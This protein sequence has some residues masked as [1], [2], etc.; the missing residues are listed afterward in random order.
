M[1]RSQALVVALLALPLGC[2]ASERQSGAS[3]VVSAS[4]AA[5]SKLAP[6]ASGA[7]PATSVVPPASGKAEQ[8]RPTTL[9][10]VRMSAAVEPLERNDKF[11]APLDALLR[12][13]RLGEV[14]NGGSVLKANGTVEYVGFEV[15]VY[16]AR[17]AVPVVIETLREL[18]APKGTSVEELRDDEPAIAHPVW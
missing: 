3:A 13:Q 11:E 18:K 12:E 4:A 6:T 2:R 5:A 7:P 9:L 16:D 15:R 8:A 14:S 1:S 10:Y 17:A